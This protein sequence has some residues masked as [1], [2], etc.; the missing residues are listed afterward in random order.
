MHSLQCYMCANKA[1]RLSKAICESN[2]R[3]GGNDTTKKHIGSTSALADWNKNVHIVM[4]M[5]RKADNFD[6]VTCYE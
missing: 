3:S 2:T 4:K 6:I 1:E 5:R